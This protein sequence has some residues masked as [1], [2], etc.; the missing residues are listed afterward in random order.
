[1]VLRE[2]KQDKGHEFVVLMGICIHHLSYLIYRLGSKSQRPPKNFGFNE[3][4]FPTLNQKIEDSAQ[5]VT[6]GILNPHK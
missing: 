3:N 4:S 2:E 5:F 1:M 6:C